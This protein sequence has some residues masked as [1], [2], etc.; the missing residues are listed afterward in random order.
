VDKEHFD[1][2]LAEMVIVAQSRLME[3]AVPR[4]LPAGPPAPPMPGLNVPAQPPPLAEDPD[5]DD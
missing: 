3:N 5:D 4:R 1:D 2:R